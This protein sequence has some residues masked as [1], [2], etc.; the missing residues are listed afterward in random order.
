MKLIRNFNDLRSG[1]VVVFKWYHEDVQDR[2]KLLR[3]QGMPTMYW[4]SK[5]LGVTILGPKYS[6]TRVDMWRQQIGSTDYCSVV[7]SM[8]HDRKLFKLD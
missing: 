6:R 5:L 1:D 7:Q 2:R 3:R 4:T 8:V